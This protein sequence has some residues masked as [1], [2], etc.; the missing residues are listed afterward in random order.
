MKIQ[1]HFYDLVLRHPFRIAHDYREVQ[2]TLIVELSH[3][4]LAGYGEATASRYYQVNRQQM[5][6]FLQKHRFDIEKIAVGEPAQ[7][8]DQVA[9]LPQLPTF[10]LCAL[11]QAYHDWWGKKTGKHVFEYWDLAPRNT[12]ISNYTLGIDSVENMVAKMK[13]QPWPLYKIKLGTA[14]DLA[15][16]EALRKYTDAKFRVDANCAWTAE[17]T[18]RF[19]GAMGALG[20]EF[21][22]QPLKADDWEGME[23]VYK[24]SALPV[25]ADESC[26]VAS[27]VERCVGYFHGVNI[28]LTKCGGLTPARK[29]IARAKELGLATMVGCM[30]ESSVG[31]SAIAQLL[32]L[33]DFVDMDGVL[34]IR[35]DPA[36]GVKVTPN[37]A[38]FPHTKGNGVILKN[39]QPI[40]DK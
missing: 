16:V 20:V 15:I 5:A 10:L 29:M 39:P 24:H 12:P 9:Q 19:S 21:I 32:P 13:E 7:F 23:K 27:D 33:L 17:Q 8:W 35:N 30:T 40:W 37:G 2:Q 28:K 22:E 38:V 34:L 14:D 3:E 4:G 18:I 11:D 26:I 31:I 25:I 36:E 6:D 1:V